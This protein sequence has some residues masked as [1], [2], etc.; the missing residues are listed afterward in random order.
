M[1]FIR[2]KMSRHVETAKQFA[3]RILFAIIKTGLVD[4]VTYIFTQIIIMDYGDMQI[5]VVT[6]SVITLLPYL[7][8]GKKYSSSS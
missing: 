2:T 1:G 8:N 6:L 4:A 3:E 5:H 7:T